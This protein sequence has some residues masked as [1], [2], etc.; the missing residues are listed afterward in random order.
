MAAA[1]EPAD[2]IR[3][4]GDPAA[5][6]AIYNEP[7]AASQQCL[8]AAKESESVAEPEI[9]NATA[10]Y[11]QHF[12]PSAV[13]YPHFKPLLRRSV[14]GND[15]SEACSYGHQT[16]S[17]PKDLP[18][19]AATAITDEPLQVQ[20]CQLQKNNISS[21]RGSSFEEL[22][23]AFESKRRVERNRNEVV[24]SEIYSRPTKCDIVG[25]ELCP[26]TTGLLKSQSSH[27]ISGLSADGVR[28][29]SVLFDILYK[30]R[31]VQELSQARD[32]FFDQHQSLDQL[33]M[34]LSSKRSN[35]LRTSVSAVSSH[36]GSE[37]KTKTTRRTKVA[38]S[39]NASSVCG[40]SSSTAITASSTDDEP[41]MRLRTRITETRRLGQSNGSTCPSEDNKQAMTNTKSRIVPVSSGDQNNKSK[42][43]ATCHISGSARNGNIRTT[44]T[45]RLRAAALGEI[46]RCEFTNLF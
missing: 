11:S 38:L 16:S 42:G 27:L 14:P 7:A 2:I 41:T 17:L 40:A 36:N 23:N 1:E 34:S 28:D 43:D 13:T 45:S 9:A 5:R 8:R 6:T 19:S 26:A 20:W 24:G 37:S 31:Q 15:F 10:I 32:S 12:A 44:K 22:D 21:S 39:D 33:N 25:N 29:T 30:E 3:S 46:I 18:G 4:D 35:G